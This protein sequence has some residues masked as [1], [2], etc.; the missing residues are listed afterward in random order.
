[1]A[2]GALLYGDGDVGVLSGLSNTLQWDAARGRAALASILP[3]SCRFALGVELRGRDSMLP[4]SLP[5]PDKALTI[6][7]MVLQSE[8]RVSRLETR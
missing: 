4:T 7:F 1:M 6:A 5:P 3:R 2:P 8:S